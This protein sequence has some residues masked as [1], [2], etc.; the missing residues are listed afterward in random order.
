MNFGS[1]NIKTGIRDATAFS[2]S[3]NEYIIYVHGIGQSN[4]YELY[5]LFSN[6]RRILRVNVVKNQKTG[7]CKGYGFVV[8]V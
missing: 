5:S 2:G 4:E 7:Q 3:A 6:C 8:F 1:R